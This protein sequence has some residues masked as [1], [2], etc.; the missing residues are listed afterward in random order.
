MMM[1]SQF[2]IQLIP[3]STQD[4]DESMDDISSDADSVSGSDGDTASG[5]ESQ[6]NFADEADENMPDAEAGD[7][8]D[9]VTVRWMSHSPVS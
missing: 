5:D 6:P 3:D 7:Y 2:L 9:S 8:D 4:L 1:Y